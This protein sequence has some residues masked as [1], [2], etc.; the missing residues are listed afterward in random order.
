MLHSAVLC[1][2][3]VTCSK[4]ESPSILNIKHCR[5]HCENSAADDA[6]LAGKAADAAPALQS[7]SASSP[8]VDTDRNVAVQAIAAE[9][10]HMVLPAMLKMCQAAVR[11][12][13]HDKQVGTGLLLHQKLHAC[14]LRL[15]GI[16]TLA[17]ASVSTCCWP[18]LHGPW[19]KIIIHTSEHD[20]LVFILQGKI[21][22]SLATSASD[23]EERLDHVVQVICTGFFA[24]V[25]VLS[26]LALHSCKHAHHHADLDCRLDPRQSMSTL[27]CQCM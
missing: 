3:V 15:S 17:A 13:L 16:R 24:V 7:A 19:Y 10:K 12:T 23:V 20:T 25:Q 2:D 21:S 8:T 14:T 9:L 5:Q 11:K 4:A 27:T 18:A 22:K 6:G 26:C 1:F